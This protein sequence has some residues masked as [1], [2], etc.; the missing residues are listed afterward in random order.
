MPFSPCQGDAPRL[1]PL[2]FQ[3][4]H[5]SAQPA[6]R[7]AATLGSA[8]PGV[9][10]GGEPEG[11]RCLAELPPS[12]LASWSYSHLTRCV[13]GAAAWARPW[14][15]PCS[16]RPSPLSLPCAFQ[17][18]ECLDLSKHGHGALSVVSRHLPNEGRDRLRLELRGLVVLS[19]EP[20]LVRR[21]QWL[22]PRWQRGAG[23]CSALGLPGIRQLRQLLPAL[24]LPTSAA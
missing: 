7:E 6:H 23:E 9:L 14:A 5:V 21:G 20:S 4:C 24:L 13:P 10:C 3:H 22:K 12:S 15:V 11:Q 1:E 17:V 8:G 18:L 2:L 16:C 19:K